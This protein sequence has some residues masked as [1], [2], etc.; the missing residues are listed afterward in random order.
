MNYIIDQNTLKQTSKQKWR[1]I[2][3]CIIAFVIGVS[4]AIL[5]FIFQQSK[6]SGLFAFL[7]AFDLALMSAFIWFIIFSYLKPLKNYRKLVKDSFKSSHLCN[8]VEIV[9]IKST[10]QH[11][12]GNEILIVTGRE[13]DENKKMYIYLLFNVE[14]PLKLHQFYEIETY[15]GFLIGYEEKNNG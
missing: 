10:P 7:I 4:I 6:L 8:D 5:L 1:Y 2:I 9:E 11:Y 3:P 12:L 14:N 13:I 15:H